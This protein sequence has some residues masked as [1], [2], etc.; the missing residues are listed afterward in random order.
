MAHTKAAG[1]TKLGRDSRPKYLGVKLSGGQA[2]KTG[3]VIIRQ[4]GIKFV[5]GEGVRLGTDDTIYA[6]R[7]G[8][9]KFTTK[10]VKKYDGRNRLVKIVNV[11]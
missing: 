3:N 2:A 10:R 8:H 5:P 6:I 9:V 11:L 1:T 7:D 4:R